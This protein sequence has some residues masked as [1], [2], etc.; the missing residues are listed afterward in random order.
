MQAYRSWSNWFHCPPLTF[1]RDTRAKMHA[2]PSGQRGR[3]YSRGLSLH[4]LPVGTCVPIDKTVI[5]TQHVTNRQ[6]SSDYVV[7][8][9]HKDLQRVVTFA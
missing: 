7:H 2:A 6:P 1:D 5:H 3:A 8:L 9:M 4:G